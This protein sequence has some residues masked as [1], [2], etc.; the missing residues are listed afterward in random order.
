MAEDK[1]YYTV[2]VLA[3]AFAV[4]EIMSREDKWELGRLAAASGLPKGTLQ[5]ILLT[6][7][8]LGFIKREKSQYALTLEFYRLGQR[9]AENNS[10]LEHARP[11]CRKL[12]QSV[13]E[14]VNLC[15]PQ[16]LDMVVVEQQVSWQM[17]RLD[18]IIG[19][20]FPIFQSASGK[21][22]CAFM[23]ELPFLRLLQEIRKSRPHLPQ[24]DVDSFIQELE[25][26]R[27][28]GV[29]FDREEIFAGVRCVSVP[30][31]SYS[32]G[33]EATVSCS[34]P[35][36]RVTKESSDK[37]IAEVANCA[38]MIS[39]SL[40]ALPRS[41]APCTRSMLGDEPAS[42]PPLPAALPETP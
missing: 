34:V 9:I 42:T 4:I 17:L 1:K 23:D 41:F 29:A 35:T 28:E 2:G 24:Q 25:A 8:E 27:R 18:S 15:I 10:L 13:N 26:V 31:F 19:S 39:R 38:A 12:M 11:F 14:T 40:G 36:V 20:S 22:Y 37:L 32:G 16:N 30:V 7:V 6:L 3:K 21:A 5:R 33:I